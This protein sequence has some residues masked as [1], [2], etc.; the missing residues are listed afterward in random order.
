M[1]MGSDFCEE[2]HKQIETGWLAKMGHTVA[3]FRG[4]ASKGL[5]FQQE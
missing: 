3:F 1:G 2:N 4:L 5:L